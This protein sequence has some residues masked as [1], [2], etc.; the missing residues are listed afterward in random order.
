MNRTVT[1]VIWRYISVLFALFGT[2][3]VEEICRSIYYM[4]RIAKMKERKVW[5]EFPSEFS[6]LFWLLVI[7]FVT[8]SG[9][10]TLSIFV[11]MFD[12]SKNP[13]NS[14]E[15]EWVFEATALLDF[16]AIGYTLG[17]HIKNYSS[18]NVVT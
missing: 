6:S 4:H 8:Y 13:K 7:N 15:A 11:G 17:L 14:L 16:I 5:E 2:I 3:L 18:S 10:I 9:Y 12:I 1:N